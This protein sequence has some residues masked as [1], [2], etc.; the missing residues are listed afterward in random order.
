M[1]LPVSTASRTLDVTVT[2]ADAQLAPGDGDDARRAGRRHPTARRSPVPTCSSWSS[3]RRS[4]PSAGTSSTTRRR[5][6]TPHLPT[7]VAATYGRD[8]IVLVDPRGP[9]RR[10]RR[11]TATTPRRPTATTAAAATA[12]RRRRRRP[13]ATRPQAELADRRRSRSPARAPAQAVAVRSNF[14]AVALFAPDV[15]TDADGHAAVDVAAPRQPHPLPRDGRRRIR[16]PAVRHR[17]G[18][19]DRRAAA[20]G[21]PDARRASSTSATAFELP[22]VVQN[23]TDAP[24]DADVVVETANLGADAARRRAGHRP[25]QR[26]GRGALPAGRRGGRAGARCGSPRSAASGPTRRPCRCPSTPRRRRRRSPPTACSTTG[27][28]SS[29]CWRRPT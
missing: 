4:S 29:R 19:R 6:S 12:A 22:V 27:R 17:R 20:D 2:P 11:A 14:D 15:T 5:R 26:P 7:E 9:P 23:D 10:R 1:T 28:S 25:G 8:G 3:T 18:Q 24:L 16:R 21:P 13:P